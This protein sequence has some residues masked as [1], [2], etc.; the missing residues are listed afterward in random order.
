MKV[1]CLKAVKPPRPPAAHP[2]NSTF[3]SSESFPSPQSPSPPV[4]EGWM[5]L[6]WLGGY[7]PEGCRK[8]CGGGFTP[9]PNDISTP[10]F[11]G[12]LLLFQPFLLPTG[13]AYILPTSTYIHYIVSLTLATR[14][15]PGLAR[16]RPGKSVLL[17]IRLNDRDFTLHF[18]ADYPRVCPGGRAYEDVGRT[19]NSCTRAR[20]S[21]IPSEVYLTAH[22]CYQMADLR[23]GGV[24][25]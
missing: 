1:D 23:G 20:S 2:S 13:R 14:T 6:V 7:G 18:L 3:S 15:Q 10:E 22:I 12:M 24:F 9:V 25:R 21:S 8:T 11:C 4:A 5:V 16:A 19:L 17:G